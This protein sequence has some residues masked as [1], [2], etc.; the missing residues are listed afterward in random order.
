MAKAFGDKPE[1]QTSSDPQTTPN[2]SEKV[3]KEKV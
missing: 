1:V 2:P 3:E